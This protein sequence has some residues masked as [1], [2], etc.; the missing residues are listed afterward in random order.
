MTGLFIYLFTYDLLRD[1]RDKLY[2][3]IIREQGIASDV[4]RIDRERIEGW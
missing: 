4:I 1:R 3:T 2:V